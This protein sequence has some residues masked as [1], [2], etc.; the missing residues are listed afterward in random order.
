MRTIIFRIFNN[1]RVWFCVWSIVAILGVILRI[2]SGGIFNFNN[3]RIFRGL[4]WHT[5]NELPL[6]AEYPLEYYDVNH[7][8]ILFSAIIAPFAFFPIFWGVLL[9]VLCNTWL[10]Y[11]AIKQ[12]KLPPAYSGLI[13]FFAINELFGAASMQQF[14][15]GLAALLILSY[16]MVQRG[17]EKWAVLFAV[18]GTLTKIYGILGFC[19]F[20]FSKNKK[21]FIGWSFL[22]FAILFIFPML[23]SSPSYVLEQYQAWVINILDKNSQNL[24]AGL[25]NMGLLGCIRKITSN[26]NYSDL[27]LIG[28]G[29]LL[30]ICPYLRFSQY[31]YTSFGMMFLPVALLF[32]LLFSTGTEHSGY[33]LGYVAIPLWFILSPDGNSRLNLTILLIAFCST[34][35]VSDFIP[36]FIRKE[37]IYPYALKAIP[38]TLVWLKATY[39]LWFGNFAKTRRLDQIVKQYNDVELK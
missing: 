15:I 12:L 30:F 35:L 3:F 29:I 5:V 8:G 23:Y 25:Q 2:K 32:V 33:I 16:V 18:I 1:Q 10:L 20:F 22:W 31:K 4:F 7:Y 27:W 37:Y 6:Y 9:W 14:N 26:I 11:Y 24:N 36:Q 28:S 17:K 21:S 13:Y 38:V 39:D 19:F 34:F